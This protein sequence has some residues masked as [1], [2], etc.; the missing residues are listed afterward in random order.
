MKINL[1]CIEISCYS[2]IVLENAGKACQT[3]FASKLVSNTQTG[4]PIL[5][6]IDNKNKNAVV[7]ILIGR[8]WPTPISGNVQTFHGGEP[9]CSG[10]PWPTPT[11]GNVQ[12]FHG[13]EPL[14]SGRPWPTPTSGNVQTFHGGEPLCS[15]RCTGGTTANLLSGRRS[16]RTP[17]L[18]IYS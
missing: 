2:F 1:F 17:L 8:S 18:L 13:G 10:R 4:Q 9:L 6:S 14:C 16:G 11:S 7:V 5:A 12:T 3:L 15:G